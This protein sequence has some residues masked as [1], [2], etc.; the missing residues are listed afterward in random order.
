[1]APANLLDRAA[2]T[3]GSLFL[4][5][6]LKRFAA[7]AVLFLLFIGYMYWTAISDPVVRRDTVHLAEWPKGTPPATILIASDL[8]VAGPDM[9]PERVARIV[10]QINALKPDLILLAGDFISDKTL[11]TRHYS[12]AEALA[13]LAGLQPRWGTV[14]VLGNHDHWRD[15][16]E[17]SAAI[18]AGGITLLDNQAVARG[19]FVIGG[20]DD[21]F[22]AHADIPATERAMADYKGVPVMITHTP[23]LAPHL[24]QTIKLVAAGH[25]HC[26]QIR[27]PIFGAITYASSFG[28]RYACGKIVEGGRT[29]YVGAGLGTSN[30]PLRLGAVPDMWLVT[31]GR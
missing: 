27:F 6:W 18:R 19:P 17:V 20:V 4:V 22:T 3:G 16:A 28:D 25:T 31:V 12:A 24:S 11:A 7:L 23:D 8:H 30:L 26:G 1:M 10:A 21:F 29:I 9:P 2:M 5:R 13:P 14:A 15:A